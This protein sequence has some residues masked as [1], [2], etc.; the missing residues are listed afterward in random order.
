[1][2]KTMKLRPRKVAKVYAELH[3]TSLDSIDIRKK[4]KIHKKHQIRKASDE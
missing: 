3:D 4:K 1:M 2:K